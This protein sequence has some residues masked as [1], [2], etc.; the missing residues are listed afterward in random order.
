MEPQ[1]NP[2]AE[3]Q[4]LDRVHR[5][6]QKREVFTIRYI[7]NNSIEQ[8]KLLCHAV[9]PCCNSSNTDRARH[10]STF[11][12]FSRRNWDWYTNHLATGRLVRPRSIDHAGR[13]VF[14]FFGKPPH[15][16]CAKLTV[17]FI[18]DYRPFCSSSRLLSSPLS[19][20]GLWTCFSLALSQRETPWDQ[21]ADIAL[22]L[23]NK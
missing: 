13:F 10:S 4:A 21:Q 19:W 20:H 23:C 17:P 6:G 11:S 12:R 9:Q 14:F 8:V 22:K 5:I 18:R 2:M 7:V 15:C 1:W 16:Y 3:E